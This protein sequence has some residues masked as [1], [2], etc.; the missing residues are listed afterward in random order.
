MPSASKTT[1]LGLNQFSDSDSIKIA[2]YN[3]DMARLDSLVGLEVLGLYATLEALQTAHPTGTAGN[4]YAVGTES[5]NIIYLWD[6]AT[7]AW[8]SIG[9]IKGASDAADIALSTETAALVGEDDVDAAVAALFTSV[10]SSQT[11][12]DSGMNA[13][14]ADVETMGGTVTQAGD[15]A[16]F[17]ELSDGILSIPTGGGG[18]EL[19]TETSFGSV[20]PL[21]VYDGATVEFAFAGETSFGS[22]VDN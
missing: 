12:I 18:G 16:T 7:S 21:A 11:A 2:D 6:A 8:V 20:V 1:K 17:D 4:A 15:V 19:P 13:L 3:A 5:S 22:A 14:A 9:S 10:S